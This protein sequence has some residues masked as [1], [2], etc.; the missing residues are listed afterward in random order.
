[1]L[2]LPFTREQFF[3]VFAAYNDAIWPTP[4]AASALGLATAIVPWAAGPASQWPHRFAIACLAL[5]WAWTGVAYH[6]LFFAAINPA[7]LGFGALFVLQGALLAGFATTL[8]FGG[9]RRAD[10]A[11]GLFFVLYALVLYPLIG[12]W[13]GHAYP[14]APMFGVTPCPVT[15][16]TFGLLLQTK[17]RPPWA[18]IT[19]P[20][21]WSLIGGSAAF[22]LGVVQDWVLLFSG[23]VTVVRLA[24]R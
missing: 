3:E 5:M 21:V 11:I 8:K 15:I 20:L 17:R 6:G 22:L 4:V 19:I 2:E 1:M 7:A 9:A 13:S 14:A 16:F 10:S 12:H 23:I 18:L 24:T